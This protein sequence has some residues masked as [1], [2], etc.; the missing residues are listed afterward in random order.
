VY[1]HPGRDHLTWVKNHQPIYFLVTLLR[2]AHNV[3]FL[4]RVLV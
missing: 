3:D 1:A 4:S 2:L